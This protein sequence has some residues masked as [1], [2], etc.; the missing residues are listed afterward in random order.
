MKFQ[1]QF[2]CQIVSYIER[3]KRVIAIIHD[4]IWQVHLLI[5][6]FKTKPFQYNINC[7][8][9][10]SL[11]FLMNKFENIWR[12]SSLGLARGIGPGS[13]IVR[14]RLNKFQHAQKGWDHDLDHVQGLGVALYKG[15]GGAGVCTS[16][17]AVKGP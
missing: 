2:H 1:N 3:L 10:N 15:S 12:S 8:L 7:S 17:R 4:I 9:V 13:C 6:N 16:S 14:L 5:L 11:H